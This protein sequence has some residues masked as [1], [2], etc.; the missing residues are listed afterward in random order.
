MG[1]VGKLAGATN[2]VMKS[3]V[4]NSFIPVSD[5]ADDYSM[6]EGGAVVYINENYVKEGSSAK[7]YFITEIRPGYAL[8]ADTKRDFD[9]GQ[10]KIYSWVIESYKNPS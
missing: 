8:L 7:K 10:G 3:S 4:P 5:D 2:G 1:S 9:A 6:I